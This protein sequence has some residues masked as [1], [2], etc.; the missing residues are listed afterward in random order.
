MSPSP[1]FHITHTCAH[2]YTRHKL[3]ESEKLEAGLGTALP[4]QS[5]QSA[6]RAGKACGERILLQKHIL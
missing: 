2:V 5:N 4:K 1:A 6:H 3:C